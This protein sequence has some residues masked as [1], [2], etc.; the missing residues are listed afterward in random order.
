MQ[1]KGLTLIEILVVLFIM[2][3]IAIALYQVL[4]AGM[5]SWRT[6]Q[7]RTD[8]IAQARVAMDRLTR[9]TREATYMKAANTTSI[10]FSAYLLDT[11]N[12]KDVSYYYDS[13]QDILYRN[14]ASGGAK[15][16]AKYITDFD[17]TYY[18]KWANNTIHSFDPSSSPNSI[19][20]IAIDAQVTK[21]V[22]GEE[23][24]VN[25]RSTVQP[26]NYPYP[27]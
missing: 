23:N 10:N 20:M 16:M 26:R 25:L 13:A 5:K 4:N 11:T 15:E 8:I 2:S 1:R 14:E 9:E 3:F 27:Q 24:V 7:E 21:G 22:T 17:F 6:G 12:L 18:S 19:W